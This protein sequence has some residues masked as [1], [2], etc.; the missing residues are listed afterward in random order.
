MLQPVNSNVKNEPH[1][2]IANNRKSHI[3]DLCENYVPMFLCGEKRVV[4]SR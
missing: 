2:D 3:G 1:R 4:I